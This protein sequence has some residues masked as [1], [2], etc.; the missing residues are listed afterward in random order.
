M[1][2]L[3]TAEDLRHARKRIKELETSLTAEQVR[4]SRAQARIEALE[5]ALRGAWA[6]VGAVQGRR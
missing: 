2:P 6:R 3:A 5:S 1:D 4:L